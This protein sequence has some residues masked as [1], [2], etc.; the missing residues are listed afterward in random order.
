M[1]LRVVQISDSHLSGRGGVTRSNLRRLVRFI[2]EELRPECVVH[3]GDVI[4]LQPGTASDF[5][6][7]RAILDELVMPYQVVPGNHDV[8]APN[9]EPW[10]GL[11][12]RDEH[13]A[14]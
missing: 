10:M 11:G 4:A 3:S 7:A 1:E 5:R 6:A 12:T 9:A 13:V 2:N 14:E 8:G